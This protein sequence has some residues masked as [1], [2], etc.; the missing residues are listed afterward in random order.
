M[1]QAAKLFIETIGLQTER[2]RLLF[3]TVASLIILA[4]PYNALAHLS[5]WQRLGFDSAPSIGLTRAY[6]Q[7]LHLDIDAAW[8]RNPLIFLVLAVGLPLLAIDAWRLVR[9]RRD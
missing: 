5:L 1:R 6:W 7:V 9:A 3:F 8:S 4:L 2:G